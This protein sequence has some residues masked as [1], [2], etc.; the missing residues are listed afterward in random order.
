MT[1][2]EVS[3]EDVLLAA[4]RIAPYVHRTPVATSATLDADLDCE[5]VFKAE[6]LQKVGAFKARGA[7]NVVLSLPDEVAKRGVVTHSS[8]NHGQALAY[9]ARIRGIPSWIVMPRTASSV[10]IEAV[11][12][13]GAEIIL[14]EHDEREAAAARI[15][16]ESGATLVHPYDDP[17]IIAGQGTATLELIEDH[18]PFDVVVAPIGGGGLLSGM[19]V[20]AT[21][22]DASPEIVGAEPEA[23]DDAYRSLLTGVRQPGVP[24]PRTLADGLLTG[25][26]EVPF[27]ILRATGATI[28]TVSE[29]A[30]LEAARFLLFRLKLVVEPSGAVGLAALQTHRKRFIGKRVG[31]VLSGGNT[32]FAWLDSPSS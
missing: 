1:T 12:S 13:Y 9:A 3:I 18:G 17:M 10:K 31:V 14:C 27:A 30:I 11:R 7:T 29:A 25:I 6:N 26:G 8:G 22:I 4:H 19:A 28:L 23:V 21:G 16:A 24:D 5:V 2:A 15:E 32:D 20:V